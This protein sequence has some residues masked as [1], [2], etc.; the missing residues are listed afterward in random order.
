M[1]SLP[2]T[3]VFS[4]KFIQTQLISGASPIFYVPLKVFNRL[5]QYLKQ[6]HSTTMYIP[7]RRQSWLLSSHKCKRTT[8][9]FASS[10]SK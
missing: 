9:A 4:Q 1:A 10:N 5:R 6:A 7:F 3:A 8:H 2:C